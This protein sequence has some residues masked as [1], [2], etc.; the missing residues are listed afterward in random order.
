MDIGISHIES[1][2]EQD[3]YSYIT[4][5][6]LASDSPISKSKDEGGSKQGRKNRGDRRTHKNMKTDSMDS[7]L[8]SIA[9]TRDRSAFKKLFAAFAPKIKSFA[10]RN[11]VG[12]ELAEEVVQETFSASYLVEMLSRNELPKKY[13]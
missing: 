2:T 4:G 7:C 12:P 11:G 8:I 3:G 1:S 13:L 6:T 10:M 5:V 9:E